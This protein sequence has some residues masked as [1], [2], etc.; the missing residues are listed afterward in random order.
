MKELKF[1]PITA[2]QIEVKPTDTKSKNSCV[3]LLYIDSRSAADI[4]NETVGVFNWEIKYKEVAGQ[5]YGALSIY[6]EE[7]KIWVTKEDTGEESN[8]AEKKGQASDILKRCIARWG[9]DWLYHTPRI[10]IHT[11][12]DY[13]YNDKL[14]MT[15]TVKE[16]EFDEDTKEC[17]RLSIV[18]RNG[19]EVFNMFGP[20][21]EEEKLFSFTNKEIL[22]EFCKKTKPTLDEEM[23]QQL[24][25]FYRFYAPKCDQWNGNFD[26]LSLWNNWKSKI[27]KV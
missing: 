16:I 19:K 1:K 24:E 10:R 13:Y 22:I 5:I 27:R 3:L 14:T 23:K 26:T 7:R 17:T 15:F 4:L 18:D 6:D 21:N 25:N 9:C 12:A 8:I 11:P 2:D 20:K